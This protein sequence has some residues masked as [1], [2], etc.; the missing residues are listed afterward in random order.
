MIFPRSQENAEKYLDY[1]TNISFQIG[2]LR[3]FSSHWTVYSP[4]T[5]K[6]LNKWNRDFMQEWIIVEG[7]T[8]VALGKDGNCR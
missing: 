3:Q 2:F 7:L 1:A 5:D 4:D 6:M 8:V